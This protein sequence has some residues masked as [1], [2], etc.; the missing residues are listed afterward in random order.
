MQEV[1]EVAVLSKTL[2][3]RASAGFLRAAGKPM[4]NIR[5]QAVPPWHKGFA[6]G[7]GASALVRAFVA[8]AEKVVGVLHQNAPNNCPQI[9]D[10]A[11]KGVGCKVVLARHLF[12]HVVVRESVDGAI[13]PEDKEDCQGNDNGY[14][15][16]L[17]VKTND[18]QGHGTTEVHQAPGQARRGQV[19]GDTATDGV[20]QE[21]EDV[22]D[23]EELPPV[24]QVLL[25]LRVEERHLG[26]VEHVEDRRPVLHGEVAQELRRKEGHH[27]W[28]PRPRLLEGH[29]KVCS[30]QLCLLS[31]GELHEKADAERYA[32]HD[33]PVE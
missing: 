31:R 11:P 3:P 16:G 27:A 10:E 29:R 6:S 21:D 8:A 20:S 9:A 23:G 4:H 5:R 33:V 25:A 12:V 17:Q 15:Q 22:S 7:P 32:C 1:E 13:A 30:A 19:H 18:D 26:R 14:G 2:N 24:H 28:H